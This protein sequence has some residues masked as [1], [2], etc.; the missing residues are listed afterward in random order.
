MHQGD[1]VDQGSKWTDWDNK[2]NHR[3]YER[4][5]GLARIH[6]ESTYEYRRRNSQAGGTYES[7]TIP[8]IIDGY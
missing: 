5:R 8:T 1:N 3:P 2:L 7:L 6:I 4:T